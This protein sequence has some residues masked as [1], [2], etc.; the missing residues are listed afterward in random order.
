VSRLPI[1]VRLSV[2]HGLFLALT[3]L[4][5]GAFLVLELRSDLRSNIDREVT[6]SSAAI[7]RTYTTVG[8]ANFTEISAASLGEPERGAAQVLDPN[9][10]V[11][12]SY[13]PISNRPMVPPS[14]LR[15]ALAGQPQRLDTQLGRDAHSYTVLARPIAGPHGRQVLVVARSLEGIN[16][17]VRKVLILLLIAA[18]VAL[19]T[20]GLAA[21]WLVRNALVP[22]DRMRAK[23]EKIGI[24]HLHE[25]LAA[26]HPTDE[27]GQLASTLNA[28]LDRLEGGVAAKRQL[29]ADASHELRAPLAA[30]RAELDISIRDAE[31]TPAERE[32]LESVREDVSRMSL[33]VDNLLALASA[34][35]GRLELLRSRI[36]LLQTVET[37]ARPLRA[38]ADA[39]DIRLRID[40][41]PYVVEADPQWLH[42][43][44]T[45][46]IENAIKFTPRGGEV[47]ASTWS[48]HG[49]LGVSVADTGPGIP[50]EARDRVFDR[51]YRAD[52]SRSRESGGSGL[53]LAICTEIATAH[54][55]SMRVE[56]E[57]GAGSV[58]TLALP[59]RSPAGQVPDVQRTAGRV[60]G[61]APTDREDDPAADRDR[62]APVARG[63]RQ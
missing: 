9:G 7:G 20:F 31:R 38:L 25:R 48:E 52:R 30:M 1:R 58:F 3:L 60:V 4:A 49:E 22:V 55:G 44:L 12:V 41:E 45:N 36:D 33:T 13:S 43:A 28:M 29:I 2:W 21:W 14:V 5:L 16:R 23:A 34:D 11:L 17:T 46:M 27:L 56:S 47:T 50:P 19:V 61:G 57:V 53:G 24:D 63:G 15:A 51:F 39:K 54:G 32:T 10:A 8:T 62:A 26:P 6:E 18:P 40:G 42:Q 37:A 59:D 35:E